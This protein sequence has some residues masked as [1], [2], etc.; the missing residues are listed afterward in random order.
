[1]VTLVNSVQKLNEMYVTREAQLG[2][3]CEAE[4]SGIKH[5]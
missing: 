4:I 3:Y 1:M 5:L 2:L